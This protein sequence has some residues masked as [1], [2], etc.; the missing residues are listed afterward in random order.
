MAIVVHVE[1]LTGYT[2]PPP[3]AADDGD[4]TLVPLCDDPAVLGKLWGVVLLLAV[5][6]HAESV[7]YHPWRPDGGLSYVVAGV[8]YALLPPPD[9]LAGPFIAVAR[10]LFTRA[11]RGR[12]GRWLGG[13][14]CGAFELRMWGHVF[15]WD[16]VMWL[17]GERAGVEL[18]RVAPAVPERRPAEPGTAPG[19]QA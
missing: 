3:D 13:P 9:H 11:G 4:G 16:V 12:D 10:S 14:A 18:L 19:R 1:E 7:Q 17:S 8:R 2:G 15:V 5:R 6:D